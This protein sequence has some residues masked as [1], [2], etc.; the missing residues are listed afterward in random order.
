MEGK[1]LI[2][3]TGHCPYCKKIVLLDAV[4]AI[5]DNE[6]VIAIVCCFCNDIVNM[7][8]DVKI[9]LMSIDKAQEVGFSIEQM[10]DAYGAEDRWN[11]VRPWAN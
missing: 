9:E 1:E 3:P 11:K 6:T 5:K 2:V 8:K 7:D 4:E 10:K